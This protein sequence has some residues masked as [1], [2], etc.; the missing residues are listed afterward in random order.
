MTIF[1]H[2][3]LE[4]KSSKQRSVLSNFV[5][6]L[7]SKRLEDLLDYICQLSV[8]AT[9]PDVGIS[10]KKVYLDLKFLKLVVYKVNSSQIANIPMVNFVEKL[11]FSKNMVNKITI[12]SKKSNF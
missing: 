2:L 6:Q 8:V 9:I 4:S 5:Q 7:D 11:W 12:F 10:L 1:L 3:F